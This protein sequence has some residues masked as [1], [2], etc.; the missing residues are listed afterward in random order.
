MCSIHLNISSQNPCFWPLFSGLT[1][2]FCGNL[3][4]TIL[5]LCTQLTEHCTHNPV[6]L[7]H[8]KAILQQT[9]WLRW[10]YMHQTQSAHICVCMC[11]LYLIK[12]CMSVGIDIAGHC[13]H[14]VC[15]V[16]LDFWLVF[17]LNGISYLPPT[18]IQPSDMLQHVY[19]WGPILWSWRMYCLLHRREQWDDWNHSTTRQ[20]AAKAFYHKDHPLSKL[21]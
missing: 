14:R 5:Y 6:S 11:I 18:S 10:L 8:A 3:I 4:E 16:L 17:C 7:V 15:S 19:Y 13:S 20:W 21:P 2:P 12:V 1:S 9:L